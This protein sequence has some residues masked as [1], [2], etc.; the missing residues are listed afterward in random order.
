MTL[1]QGNDAKRG[2]SAAP[3]ITM[4][5]LVRPCNLHNLLIPLLLLGRIVVTLNN[6]WTAL[7]VT[8][9]LHP[10][11]IRENATSRITKTSFHHFLL[12]P[13][14]AGTA[15]IHG[16]GYVPHAREHESSSSVMTTVFICFLQ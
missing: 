11:H 15:E 3:T 14:T 10:S 5:Y 6:A 7:G 1:H 13:R 8:S 16:A 2:P 4:R 12:G 9:L